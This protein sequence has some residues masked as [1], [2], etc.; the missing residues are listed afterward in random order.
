MPAGSGV[1]SAKTQDAPSA[2]D[3]SSGEE[4]LAYLDKAVARCDDQGLQLR[5]HVEFVENVH[6]VS[7]FRLHGDVEPLSDLLALQ[8]SG[9]RLEHLSLAE[10]Q[11]LDGPP[12][13]VLLLALAAD[14]AQHLDDLARREQRL[15]GLEPTHRFY[16]P[17]YGGRFVQHPGGAGLDSAGQ[18]TRL[19]LALRTSVF[20]L[21]TEA[22]KSSTRLSPSPSGRPRSTT[23]TSTF[24]SD[25][26]ESLRASASVLACSITLNSGSLSN[27]KASAWRKEA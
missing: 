23:A 25:S 15:A 26:P 18:P 2:R 10:S 14:Q 6:H 5:V 9:E 12:D 22:E 17:L 20:I 4:A 16:N 1:S 7:A 21:G 24:L 11:L 13:V 3:S 19:R 27:V 8:A